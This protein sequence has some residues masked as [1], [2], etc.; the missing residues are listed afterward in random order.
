MEYIV[1]TRFKNKA[2]CGEVNLPVLTKV[3]LKGNTIYLK[4]KPLCLITSENAHKFFAR[5]NDKM[6][7]KRGFLTK[8]IIQ[9]LKNPNKNQQRWNKIWKNDLCQKYKRKEYQDYWLWNTAFYNAD[10]QDLQYIYNLVKE[11]ND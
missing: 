11:D 6:G 4:E 9:T 2:I 3:E 8:N 5:N 7:L 10:I 1:H